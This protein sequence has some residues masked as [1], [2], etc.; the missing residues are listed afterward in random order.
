MGRRRL[1]SVG[2]LAAVAAGTTLALALAN[3]GSGEREP[4]GG[5]GAARASERP[6]SR[7]LSLRP[8][9]PPD[10]RVVRDPARALR[11]R[12]PPGWQTFGGTLTPRLAAS[13]PGILVASTFDPGARPRR[14]CGSAPDLPETPIGPHDAL[15]HLQEELD[16]SPGTL[17][18]RP[19]RLELREQL[20]LL[21]RNEAGRNVFPW[22]CLNR[23]GIVGLRTW[24][25]AHGRLIFL[26]AV[27]GEDTDTRRRRELLGIAQGVRIGPTP[28][29]EVRVDP[30]VGR[31][32]T[33]FRL[34]LTATHTSG[35]RGRRERGYWALVQGPPK[36][37]CVIEHEAWFSEG[38]P[39]AR[40]RA[41]LD[42]RRTKGQ[43]WC[44]GRFT[45]RI[46][47]RDAICRRGA[48]HCDR[49][50]IR[51]AGRFSFSVR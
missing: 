3:G 41:V 25:R 46:R 33:R 10:A 20:R 28:P 49:V 50:Y 39:G 48:D 51:R 29:V 17:P 21:R 6:A 14:R 36:I 7:A 26:T 5:S 15:V 18:R 37:A 35:R 13:Y 1:L 8:L 16:A 9:V 11:V 2:A 42:P 34:E 45:G 40:L 22:R 43:R 12:L 19:R 31:P 47:Y 38:R 27:A 24:F 44:R 32:G 30:A 4:A 23:P